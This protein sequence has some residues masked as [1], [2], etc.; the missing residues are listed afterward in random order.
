MKLLSN[1]KTSVKLIAAFVLMSIVLGI[2]GF[3]G[4]TNLNKSNEQLQFMVE[5]RMIPISELGKVETL[6]QQIRVNIRDLVFVGETSS[7]KKEFE[8]TINTIKVEIDTK[9]KNYEAG[10]IM[11]A[12]EQEIIDGLYPALEEYYSILEQA[13][14]FAYSDDKEGYLRLAPAFNESGDKVESIINELIKHNVELAQKSNEESNAEFKQA[15]INTIIVIIVAMV[16]SIASGYLIA[17][18]ISR[19]LKKVVTLLG[20]VANG[21]LSQTTDIDRKDEV[22]ELAK[23]TNVMVESLR[24]LMQDVMNTSQQVAASSEELTASA[25]QT[26]Q[27]T[28]E[29][30]NAIQGIAEGA[31]TSTASLEES[32]TGLEEVTLGIQNIADSSNTIA[33]AGSHASAQA[34]MGGEFVGKT[35]QQIQAINQSVNE[36]SEAIKSLDKRSQEIGEITKVITEIANQTN[37]LA[38]NAAIE[39]ARAGEHGKGFAVVADEVR[40]L[41]EQSQQSSTQISELIN[42]IQMDMTRSNDSINQ[43]KSDVKEGLAIVGKTQESFK[44]ILGSLDKVSMQIDDMAATAEQMSASAQEVSAN[45]T[46]SASMSRESSMNSQSVAASTEEQLA[47]MEEISSASNNLSEMAMNLQEL[48]SKFKL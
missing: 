30:T 5:E 36:S 38:L 10:T 6:Y 9:L 24:K 45:I 31:E 27:A 3:Y 2:V 34:K 37:L 43:V 15:K 32:S 1:L 41:A 4:L 7:K 28:E 8:D 14:I 39:A 25:E 23:S 44:V 48:V 42:E 22:G 47:S 35:V 26:S 16:L 20:Q 12:S 29:I 33:E 13:K 19:P 11:L 21:D 17:Q 40:K 46:S 18:L